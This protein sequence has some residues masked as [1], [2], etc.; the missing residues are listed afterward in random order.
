MRSVVGGINVSN[1]QVL[2]YNEC[3]IVKQC[4]NELIIIFI[5]LLKNELKLHDIPVS[6]DSYS[7][8]SMLCYAYY[9][10]Y[11]LIANNTNLYSY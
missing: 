1:K 7:H 3:G 2:S 6:F 4:G 11:F 10:V 8:L 5:L 9:I